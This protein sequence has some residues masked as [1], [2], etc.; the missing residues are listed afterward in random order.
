MS[1]SVLLQSAQPE[2]NDQ[3]QQ[4]SQSWGRAIRK[5]PIAGAKIV[6][7]GGLQE[8]QSLRKLWNSVLWRL[9]I[10]QGKISV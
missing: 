10:R 2:Q 8:V 7:A 3:D 4:T 6:P 5:Q 1:N 9:T